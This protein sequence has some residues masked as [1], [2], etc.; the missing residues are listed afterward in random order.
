MNSS[1]LVFCSSSN[2][3]S[4]MYFSE[5]GLLGEQL[6]KNSLELVYG[7]AQ[8]GLMG[9]V[10]DSALQNG[11]SVKGVIP[12]Y[13]NKPGVGHEGLTELKIVSDL[14]DRKRCMLELSDYIIVFPGGMGTLDEFTE[15]ISLKQ[16]NQIKQ[17]ILVVNFMDFWT[18][19]IQYMEELKL[20]GMISQDLDDLFVLCD[21]SQ[22]AVDYILGDMNSGN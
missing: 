1:V 6:A 13:L 15:V 2:D 18:P 19:F 21:G 22:Q 10:A 8:V 14:L 17:P 7:G 3:V 11:G 12:E 9:R 20:R 4:P 5:I 16:L